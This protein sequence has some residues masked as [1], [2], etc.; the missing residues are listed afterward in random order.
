MVLY[1]PQTHS[2][3]SSSLPFS[4]HIPL[5]T[6]RRTRISLSF[7]P[8]LFQSKTNSNRNNYLRQKLLKTLTK[9]DLS[10]SFPQ[11]LHDPDPR[12]DPIETPT[13]PFK[14]EEEVEKQQEYK[15]H[16]MFSSPPSTPKAFRFGSPKLLSNL[17]FFFLGLFMLETLYNVWILGS[18]DVGGNSGD[19]V[20]TGDRKK[21]R[22]WGFNGDEAEFENKV[23]EIRVLAREARETEQRKARSEAS[24][25][26][27]S[28]VGDDGDDVNEDRIDVKK[29]VNMR[30]LKLQKSR[31]KKPLQ[32]QNLDDKDGGF[33]SRE[34]P[35]ITSL[36][37]RIDAEGFK[38]LENDTNTSLRGESDENGL[39]DQ[40]KQQADEVNA[41][42]TEEEVS[43][44][45]NE[46]LL[47]RIVLK[48]RANEE[49]GREPY[50]GLDSEEM[51]FF[52]ALMQKFRREGPDYAKQWMEKRID[53]IDL[54]NGV[55]EKSG[56]EKPLEESVRPYEK[57]KS[58][59]QIET[60][61]ITDKLIEILDSG[62]GSS[63]SSIDISSHVQD[64]FQNEPSSAEDSLHGESY[65]SEI[66]E[67]TG[68]QNKGSSNE[69]KS[70]ETQSKFSQHSKNVNQG[71]L[72][73]SG[74]NTLSNSNGNSNSQLQARKV[75][76]SMLNEVKDN[77]SDDE[78][79]LWWLDLPYVVAI[80]L[81]RGS[82]H[83]GSEGLYSLKMNSHS[84]NESCSCT[85]AFEDRGDA[86][87]FCYLL[88]SFFEGLGDFS[89]DA[90]PLSTKDLEEGAKSK[91]AKVLVVRKG[92]VQLYAG[93]PLADVERSLRSILK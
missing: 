64:D 74:K 86:S 37:A 54:S 50:N 49:A 24:M 89:A 13:N 61:S 92:Q 21:N 38:G 14:R 71:T 10:V 55:T 23:E 30:L 16:E 62:S 87:N 47:K 68:K 93:Q 33:A 81:R 83:E 44:W 22:N 1:P 80:L 53:G 43:H 45:L 66:P 25:S 65:A 67:G 3:S 63:F 9:P 28:A 40:G 48:V 32:P 59:G 34:E 41:D 52:L 12:T 7:H 51:N 39:L 35:P 56:R 72:S 46:E 91:G 82:D 57:I 60:S 27:S 84:G 76:Q 15:I 4:P 11:T 42:S 17:V 8:S 58:V 88:E 19:G 31:G 69:I 36:K 90:V 20:E 29:E 77:Q 79:D 5:S 18:A 26:S 85:I 73:I 2:I 75:K 70:R 6:R 78:N